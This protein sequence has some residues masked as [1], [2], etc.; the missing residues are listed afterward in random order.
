MNILPQKKKS[1]EC[2]ATPTNKKTTPKK[3]KNHCHPSGVISTPTP[4]FSKK[5][6]K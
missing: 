4:K 3:K 5:T 2:E 1:R 6:T